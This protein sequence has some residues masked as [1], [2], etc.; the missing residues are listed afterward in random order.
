M[1][2]ASGETTVTPS[3]RAMAE[4]VRAGARSAVD[5][6]AASTARIE[7]VDPAVCAFVRQ[8]APAAE[9]AERIDRYVARGEDP[10]PLAG[11]PVALKDNLALKDEALS[12]CSRALA[13]YVS[14][15]S[16]TAVEQLIA[17]GAVPVGHTNMDE[18]GMGSSCENSAFFA[19]RNPWDLERV[20]GGSSGGSA[21]A[22][23]AACVPVALGTDTGGSIRQPAALCGVVGLKPTYGR[24]SRYGLVAFAS[25]LDQIGPMTRSVE[26]AAVV[27]GVLAGHDARDATSST[28]PVG[29]YVS[30]LDQGIDGL[31]IGV[32][33]QFA[34]EG[35]V[36]GLAPSVSSNWH[37]VI[38]LMA[39]AGAQIV[40]VD[41]PSAPAAI[42]T[43][44]VLANSE[45]SANLARFD[46][47][48]YGHRSP[49]RSL[50][51]LYE[52]SRSE[53]LGPEVKRRI[54]LG[55]FALSSGYYDAYYSK[56]SAVAEQLN[57]ELV[58]AFENC[59]VLLT[60][61]SPTSAFELGERTTDPLA[62][63]LSDAFTTVASLSG[64]P[65]LAVPS[66]LDDRGLPMSVQ[67]VGPRFDEALILRCG[68]AVE[69]LVGGIG[70][71]KVDVAPRGH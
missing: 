19:T 25:S 17:A 1:R 9:I 28:E 8:H 52:E 6:L 27:L 13:G 56:A 36:A 18:F 45:A 68:R 31:R 24:V 49:A 63:Y 23:A 59:D 48:R 12:C 51:D 16:G 39:E 34:G 20:P 44:Y 38:S 32:I 53:G 3:I 21:A 37:D 64:L 10:G 33:K 61:T 70:T 14:P 35:A 41:L 7:R 66:G 62:M 5:L 4:D 26:D 55:T 43:Y 2:L 57:R 42:A 29:D 60:P 69:Q 71:P 46:G 11:I 50:N 15:F 54:L 67:I 65:A 47:I 40:Q 58:A 30:A 22:V